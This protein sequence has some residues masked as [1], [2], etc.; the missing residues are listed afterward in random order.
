VVAFKYVD[1]LFCFCMGR[2]YDDVSAGYGKRKNIC[3]LFWW[4]AAPWPAANADWGDPGIDLGS[5]LGSVY[6][7]TVQYTND[8]RRSWKLGDK[9]RFVVQ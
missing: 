4:D 2:V 3:G 6:L 7:G 8:W 9:K 5:S 1:E